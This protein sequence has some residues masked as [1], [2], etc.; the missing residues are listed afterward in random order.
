M[1]AYDYVTCGLCP[2]I[3]RVPVRI[4]NPSHFKHPV[5][6]VA[7]DAGRFVC[8][9]ADVGILL[10]VTYVP[11]EGVSGVCVRVRVRAYV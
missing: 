11:E 1:R 8:V 2:G 3:V 7:V 9:E 5:L 6:S 4:I 10:S